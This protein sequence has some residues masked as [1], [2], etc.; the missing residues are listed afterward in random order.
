MQLAQDVER[1]YINRKV[2]IENTSDY[3]YV[4]DFRGETWTIKAHSFIVRPILAAERFLGQPKFPAYYLP[5]GKTLAPGS[6]PPKALRIVELTPKEIQEIE[7]KT[8]EDV[9][10]DVQ[11]AKDKMKNMC[12]ICGA[13]FA[14]EKGLQGHTTRMHPEYEPVSSG[15]SDDTD[16]G[17]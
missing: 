9:K 13:T 4:E 2:K 16:T 17:S 1:A 5:D 14:H 10:K 11:K 12:A 6:P 7:G 8:V 3:D 15:D